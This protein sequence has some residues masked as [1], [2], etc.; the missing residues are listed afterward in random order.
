MFIGRETKN[1]FNI[2]INIFN[3]I[4]ALNRINYLY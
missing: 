4:F 1:F 3:V 2:F